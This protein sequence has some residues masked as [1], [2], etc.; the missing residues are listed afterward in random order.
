MTAKEYLEQP[1]RLKE[2]I[3]SDV[4]NLASLRSVVEKVTTSLS[5]TAG[6][7]GKDPRSF[8]NTMINI[9]AEEEKIW[10]K[11]EKLE[12]L[13]LDVLNNIRKLK[14]PKHQAVLRMRYIEQK[15]WYET[16]C[17]LGVDHRYVYQLH[18]NAIR[19]FENIWHSKNI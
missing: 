7:G 17:S 18:N 3:Q 19:D 16:A 1:G 4:D 5:F 6:R 15:T 8:E 13:I 10:E 12:S 11:T 9:K 14:N 2:E